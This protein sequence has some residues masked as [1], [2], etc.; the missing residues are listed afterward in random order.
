LFFRWR[1]NFSGLSGRETSLANRD[2]SI[3][4]DFDSKSDRLLGIAQ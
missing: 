2:L 3:K 1:R 4:W